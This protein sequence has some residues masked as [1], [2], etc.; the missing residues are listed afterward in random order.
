METTKIHDKTVLVNKREEER[1][2]EDLRYGYRTYERNLSIVMGVVLSGMLIMYFLIM[3]MFGLEVNLNF[4]YLNAVFYVIA[5]SVAFW[6]FRKRTGFKIKYF[7]G[8]KMG[9]IICAIGALIFSVFMGVY[10]SFDHE[11]MSYVQRSIEYGTYAT[12]LLTAF[13]I[14]SEGFVG[15]AITAFVLLPFFKE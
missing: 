9:V 13:A 4:R 12:P 7:Q 14:F 8:L 2:E 11:F 15:G 10:L 3:K 6:Q 5:L 1:I